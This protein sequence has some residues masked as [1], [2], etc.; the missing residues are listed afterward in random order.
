MQTTSLCK[1]L[2]L[3]SCFIFYFP[4]P[5]IL[6][7]R[8]VLP[9]K[10]GSCCKLELVGTKPYATVAIGLPLVAHCHTS[11]FDSS[12]AYRS[13][14][15]HV[16]PIFHCASVSVGL[17]TQFVHYCLVTAR[18]FMP[19]SLIVIPYTILEI[20]KFIGQLLVYH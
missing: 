6:G 5:C 3:P 10:N 14:E 15:I 4:N 11:K 19:A 17:P 12:C 16:L 13:G 8:P 2:R 1:R 20:S 18:A 7:T 9:C